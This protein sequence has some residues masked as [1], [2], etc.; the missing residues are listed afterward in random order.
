M[1]LVE[2]TLDSQ[3]RM[4]QLIEIF[5]TDIDLFVSRPGWASEAFL[6]KVLGISLPSWPDASVRDLWVSSPADGHVTEH[7]GAKDRYLWFVKHFYLDAGWKL[8]GIAMAGSA[9]RA[10]T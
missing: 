2:R 10:I 5:E 3:P 9:R 7:Y 6:E 1:S 8:K 4:T